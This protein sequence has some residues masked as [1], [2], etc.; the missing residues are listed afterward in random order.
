MFG[1]RCDVAR[2]CRDGSR[3]RDSNRF[4]CR[5]LTVASLLAGAIGATTVLTGG[6]AAA[7]TYNAA[8]DPYSMASVTQQTGATR[9]WDAGY[10]G[11]GVDVA[12]IDSGVVAVEGLDSPEKLIYGPDLSL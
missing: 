1:T 11:R 6:V 7:S 10:T 2:V 12:V 9:W 3:G 4:V 8:S 5:L